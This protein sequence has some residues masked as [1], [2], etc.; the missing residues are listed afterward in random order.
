MLPQSL[1][2]FSMDDIRS[3]T[4]LSP[5][6]S[7][8]DKN[9]VGW[10][11]ESPLIP[12]YFLGTTWGHHIGY[13]WF[14]H[15]FRGISWPVPPAP[16][17]PAPAPNLHRPQRLARPGEPFG[18]SWRSPTL[19]C[20]SLNGK[21]YIYNLYLYLCLYLCLCLYLY[22]NYYTILYIIATCITCITS[23]SCVKIRFQG[24]KQLPMQTMDVDMAT[25]CRN[26][27]PWMSLQMQNQFDFSMS[28]RQCVESKPSLATPVGNRWNR[29][30]KRQRISASMVDISNVSLPSLCSDL[31]YNSKIH[32]STMF[33]VETCWNSFINDDLPKP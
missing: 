25:T 17:V 3:S 23:Q 12:G 28:A 30:N 26:H 9:D 19:F 1:Y 13:P 31:G 4:N 5:P 18:M 29:S 7:F 33:L 11:P 15:G 24:Q 20:A 2:P 22:Y 10:L 32:S 27:G 16:T 6:E 21:S 14:A 8:G